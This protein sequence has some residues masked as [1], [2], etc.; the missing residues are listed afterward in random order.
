MKEQSLL[1]MIIQIHQDLNP[2]PAKTGSALSSSSER[3]PAC[4]ENII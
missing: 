3:T 1:M 2:T 4:T